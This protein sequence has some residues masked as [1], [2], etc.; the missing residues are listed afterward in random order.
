VFEHR[1]HRTEGSM[2]V[3]LMAGGT[4]EDTYGTLTREIPGAVE[5]ARGAGHPLAL[6][7]Y[8]DKGLSVPDSVWRRETAKMSSNPTFLPT[9]PS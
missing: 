7:V 9:A 6:L 8:F 1:I 5:A 2:A 3:R 4:L